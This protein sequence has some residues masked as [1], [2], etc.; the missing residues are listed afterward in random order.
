M[1]QKGLGTNVVTQIG[2]LVND[3]ETTANAYA[4]LFQMD[5]PKISWTDPGE[6][7]QTE[8]KG[9]AS[10]ARAKLA[11]FSMG[12]VQIELIEP[13]LTP[14]VWRDALNEQGEGVHHIAFAIDGMS[15]KIQ[16]FQENGAPLLQRGE[17]T[18]GRYAYLDTVPEFKVLIELLENDGQKSDKKVR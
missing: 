17:F 6:V 10:Q 9:E 18:G 12:Q 13:D 8:Y 1:E 4:K 7:A 14:S 2:I 11:F 15:E 3:I 16:L 5:V